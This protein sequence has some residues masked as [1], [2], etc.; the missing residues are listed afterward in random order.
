MKK[1]IN[2]VYG[3]VMLLAASGTFLFL[4]ILFLYASLQYMRI[5]NIGNVAILKENSYRPFLSTGE[6]NNDNKNY[7]LTKEDINE[8]IKDTNDSIVFQE[9][10]LEDE[11]NEDVNEDL[12]KSVSNSVI[13]SYSGKIT[14]YGSD[15]YGCTSMMTASGYDLSSGNIYYEDF[16]YGSIR[17]VA[18]DN[19][20]PFGT[21]VRIDCKLG[22]IIAIVLD[23]G[24]NVGKDKIVQFDLL[25]ESEE[26][27][28]V[29]GLSDAKFEILRMGY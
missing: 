27:S 9:E 28:S 5:R 19:S 3:Y 17:I 10:V 6:E 23:R 13:E 15:C 7:I 21:I 2:N 22:N 4:I 26:A 29:L 18:G 1:N 16:D 12:E 8:N 20:Y 24:G 11:S 14:G 25:F